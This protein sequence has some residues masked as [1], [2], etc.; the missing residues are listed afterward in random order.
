MNSDN[1]RYATLSFYGLAVIV[2]HLTT[3]I[4]IN[5]YNLAE[6]SAFTLY[7]IEK[8]VWSYVDFTIVIFTIATTQFLIKHTNVEKKIALFFPLISGVIRFLAGILNIFLII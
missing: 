2:D 8:G 3:N 5:H 4:G 6:S 1:L 7:L